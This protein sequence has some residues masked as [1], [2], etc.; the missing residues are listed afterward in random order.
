MQIN[1][2]WHIEDEVSGL[3]LTIIEGEQLDRLRIELTGDLIVTNRE[4]WFRKDG[5]YD[6]SGSGLCPDAATKLR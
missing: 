5:S 6:G 1:G 4:F 3:R 2:R